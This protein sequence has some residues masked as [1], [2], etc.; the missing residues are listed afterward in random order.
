LPE[1]KEKW[2]KA[3]GLQKPSMAQLCDYVNNPLLED[4]CSHMEAE[5]QSK[6]MLEYSR[7]SMQFGWNVKYKKAG[8]TLCALYPME[9]YYIALVV[10][11]D[12]ERFE[13]ESMLPF[14]TTYTQQ[15]W[16][17]TK[18]GMGQKWLMIHVTDH[19]I[20]EDVK[21]LIAIRRNKKK[22]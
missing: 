19:M 20:L 5:Y 9:G 2:N 22:K 17:E 14:F 6:P 12:R 11:G 1:T 13:T 21:Q 18:T 4:L 3:N 10:I 15:L 7:C 16:L 8:R